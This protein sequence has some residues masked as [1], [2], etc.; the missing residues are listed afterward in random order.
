MIQQAS[1]QQARWPV[2]LA[3]DPWLR[4]SFDVLRSK[5]SEVPWT[6]LGRL[7]TR[8]ILERSDDELVSIWQAAREW[9]SR[10]ES[11]AHHG[12]YEL[13][14]R[15]QLRGRKVLD[16]GCGLAPSTLFFAEQGA[17]V[18]FLDIVESNLE[19]VRRI[20]RAKGISGVSFCYLEDLRALEELPRD[21]DFILALG[22]LITLPLEAARR[23]AQALVEHLPPGGR[24]IEL[25]YPKSRWVREGKLPFD[26]WGAKTDGGAPWMEWYDLAKVELRLA[27]ARFEVVLSF[28]FCGGEFNWFD[29]L[30]VT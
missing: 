7:D 21:Y 25:G 8:Q 15:E 26:R 2:D 4:K 28:E 1:R 18:T 20:A 13:L 19:F 9:T 27:P 5:W 11:F 24:W 14:Y 23:Q 29:L 16:V 30:R 6:R 17:L 12:W 22:S 3:D 10:A